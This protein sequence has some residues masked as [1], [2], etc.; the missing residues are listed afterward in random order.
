M[1]NFSIYL[2]KLDDGKSYLFA[3]YEYDGRDHD[4]DMARLARDQ[5]NIDWLAVTDLMQVPLGGQKTWVQME[6][7]YHND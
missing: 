1:R 7:V 3:Y 6:E 4:G 5:R 2:Q